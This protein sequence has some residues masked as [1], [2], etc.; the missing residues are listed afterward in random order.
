[1]KASIITIGDEI[2]IGQVIDTNSAWL[3]SRLAELGHSINEVVSIKDDRESIIKTLERVVPESDWVFLTG[4]LGPTKDD[5]TKKC[6]AEF[7][8]VNLSFN[9][10]V[11]NRIVDIFNQFNRKVSESHRNQSYMPESA[12]ILLNRMGTAPG[13]L[14]KKDRTKILSMPGVPYEMKAIMEDHVLPELKNAV[15]NDLRTYKKTIMTA[16]LG[17]TMI[18][19]NLEELIHTFPE[20]IKIAYLPSL[21]KVRVR[22]TSFGGSQE[23]VDRYAKDVVNI[24]GDAV[25]GYDDISLAESLIKLCT[26][27]NL[28]IGMAESCTG[29]LITHKLTSI[30]G[31]SNAFEGGVVSYTNRLK[32]KLLKVQSGTLNQNGAVSEQ[33]VIEMAKG[34]LS[35]LDVDVAISVS[36]IAGPTGGTNE[37]PVGTTWICV[38][39]SENHYAFKIRGTKDRLNNIEYAANIALN[40]LRRFILKYYK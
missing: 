28:M 19:D 7:L 6:I 10:E 4:G 39:N 14:F 27:K 15:S 38:A 36:G 22:L 31:S 17:E 9:E 37:K 8:G 16:G 2:L 30:S 12:E 18:E 32:Q 26:S 24:L 5:I 35:L 20:H 23:E 29:G 11:Y 3:G 34:T 21:A 33:T 1:M 40:S 13:M 25:Y